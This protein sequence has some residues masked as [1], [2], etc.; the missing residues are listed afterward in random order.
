MGLIGRLELQNLFEDLVTRAGQLM[1]TQHG[2][3]YIGEPG[4]AELECK[5]GIGMFS[6]QVGF[7]QQRGEGLAGTIWQ[8]GRAMIVD[9]Y[10]SW[11]GRVKN[12]D[13]GLIRSV[14]AFPLTSGSQVVGAIGLAYDTQDSRE[15]QFGDYEVELLG[16]FA[17]LASIALDNARLYTA[18]K[19]ARAAAEAANE[20]KSA[21]LA[22][23]SHELRTPLTSILGFAFLLRKRFLDVIFP[24]V[25]GTDAKAQRAVNQVNENLNIILTEGARLTE[26]INNLLDLEKIQAGKM[27]WHM[28][29]LQLPEVIRQAAAATASL[30]ENKGL[31]WAAEVPEDLPEVFGDHNRLEQVVINLI[32]NAVKFS[33]HGQITCRAWVEGAEVRVSIHDQGIGIARADQALVFEKFKQVG[34]TLTSKPK[35]TGLGLPICR[36]IVSHHGGRI[37]VESEPG[38]GSTF[39]FSLPVDGPEPNAPAAA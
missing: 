28:T 23:V 27:T 35:G 38:Q 20:A 33:E 14:V 34:D 15:H 3:I 30:F 25:P 17:H 16:R 24:Y 2:Y 13:Y 19:D 18:A 36:E 4:A 1:H 32:S 22:N 9:D 5:V 37:W 7:R 26:L 31:T 29:R 12:F 39:I 21:F 8:T 11:P 6:R 10:D